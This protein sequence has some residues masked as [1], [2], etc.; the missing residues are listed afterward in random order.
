MWLDWRCRVALGP[1][2]PTDPLYWPEA[3]LGAI[4]GPNPATEGPAFIWFVEG[5]PPLPWP[6]DAGGPSALDRVPYFTL[7][8]FSSEQYAIRI[9]FETALDP[10]ALARGMARYHAPPPVPNARYIYRADPPP[11][12][13]VMATVPL[14]RCTVHATLTGGEEAANVLHFI[15][16][17]APANSRDVAG[18]LA[19]GAKVLT[20]WQA[21]LAAVVPAP[22]GTV[23]GFYPDSARFDEVR[24][25]AISITSPAPV[26]NGKPHPVNYDVATQFVPFP[27]G[28]NTLGGASLPYEVACVM[29]LGTGQRGKSH[30][31]RTYLGPVAMNSMPFTAGSQGTYVP[32]IVDAVGAAFWTHIVTAL[33]AAPSLQLVVASIKNATVLPVTAVR[34]G[35]VP[36]S[37]RRRRKSQAEAYHLVGGVA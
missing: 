6:A 29:S 1:T 12:G 33:A 34:V 35:T 26:V 13:H 14:F 37:Q 5:L 7:F 16:L 31:G 30:R 15:D 18:C 32:A 9:A 3:P 21:F 24:V 11:E 27:A 20:A 25:A 23:A 19:V 22:I 2:D 36:D 10:V 4:I 28:G 8:S 17:G